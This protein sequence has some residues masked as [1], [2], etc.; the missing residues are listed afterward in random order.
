MNNNA[1]ELKNEFDLVC[2][3]LLH[4]LPF[5]VF[6]FNPFLLFVLAVSTSI[7]QQFLHESPDIEKNVDN[8]HVS[9]EKSAI[10]VRIIWDMQKIGQKLTYC[11]KKRCFLPIK[12]R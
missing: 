10:K 2:L 5:I 9:Y 4:Y 11:N 3:F 12:K 7:L 1:K 6:M 8:C